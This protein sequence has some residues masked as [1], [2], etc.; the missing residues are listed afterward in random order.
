MT[1]N[2]IIATLANADTKDEVVEALTAATVAQ[3]K[4]ALKAAG[5]PARGKKADLIA[6]L[7]EWENERRAA[8]TVRHANGGAAFPGVRK[9]YN[10]IQKLSPADRT[11]LAGE[12][13]VELKDGSKARYVRDI[14]RDI[15]KACVEQQ[16]VPEVLAD[17]VA[18]RTRSRKPAQ[19]VRV[20][21]IVEHL[22]AGAT[23]ADIA[24]AVLADFPT[25]K[26][27][28]A[29]THERLT[30]YVRG[31]IYHLRRGTGCTLAKQTG[32]VTIEA[33]DGV[34]T[35][36]APKGIEQDEAGRYRIAE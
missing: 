32:G 7:I 1:K 3:L 23:V 25:R 35:M 31:A 20:D 16:V 14:C 28:E 8:A 34:F 30:A 17:L 13:G 19:R 18:P 12:F 29:D 2:T 11:Q 27:G 26:N 6:S 10:A 21:V 9:L 4:S 33:K 5:R 24:T 15:A 22:L 36:K